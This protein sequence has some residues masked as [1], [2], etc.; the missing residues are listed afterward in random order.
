MSRQKSTLPI[1]PIGPGDILREKVLKR[2]GITQDQLADAMSVSRISVNQ[3]INGRR[4]VT[5]D[6]ALRLSY[7]SGTTPHFWLDLQRDVDLFNA[8]AKLSRV[9]PRLKVLRKRKV[10]RDLVLDMG[11][12]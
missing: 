9:L 12:E 4:S 11:R 2:L 8:Q 7:V 10:E 1:T 3:I 6:M 5:A